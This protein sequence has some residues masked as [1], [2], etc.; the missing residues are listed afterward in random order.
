MIQVS[1][2]SLIT[3]HNWFIKESGAIVA[4]HGGGW[5]VGDVPSNYRF[6]S[7]M[8]KTTKA[9]VFAPEYRL[10]PEHVFPAAFGNYMYIE[11][12]VPIE[13]ILFRRLCRSHSIYSRQLR[14]TWNQSGSHCRNG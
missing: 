7:N 1:D 11:L 10:A 9:I 6:Y 12:R 2:E 8:A 13:Y 4:I 14:R 3:S 5:M